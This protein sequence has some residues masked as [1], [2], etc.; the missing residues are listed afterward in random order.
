ML[1]ENK[2]WCLNGGI[3]LTFIVIMEYFYFR[4]FIRT[5]LLFGDSGDGRLITLILEHWYK[6]F[7]GKENF[8]DLIA[9]FPYKNTVAYSDLLLGFGIPYS[10]LRLFDLNMFLA[11]K[12]TFIAVHCLGSLIMGWLLFK[13]LKFNLSVCIVVLLISMYSNTLLMRTLHPQLLSCCWYPV[14]MLCI[15]NFISNINNKR[16]R[17]FYGYA[18]IAASL[19]LL[20]TGFYATY[21]YL[22][23]L[24]FAAIVAGIICLVRQRTILN[25]IWELLIKNKIEFL[26]Y[27]LT[28]LLLA[29]PFL[30]LYLPVAEMSGMRDWNAVIASLPTFPNYFNLSPNNWLY[31]ELFNKEY[32]TGDPLACELRAGYSFGVWLLYLLC[33]FFYKERQSDQKILSEKTFTN[34]VFLALGITLLLFFILLLRINEQSLWYLIYKALPGAA[35]LRAV[36]R[37]LTFLVFPLGL[38]IGFVLNNYLKETNNFL[39]LKK[40]GIL[41]IACWLFVENIN[42]GM[43]TYWTLKDAQAAI[44][45]VS[46][47]PSDCEIM[48]VKIQPVIKRFTDHF[49]YQL[50][51]W[52]ISD[53]FNLK[54]IN[55]YSG[56]FPPNWMGI[57]EINS[58]KYLANVESWIKHYQLKNVYSYNLLSQRWEKHLEK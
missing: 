31:G 49:N 42:S 38:F 30:L 2:K 4:N 9:F 13:K 5:D 19:I 8:A 28:T 32:F 40:F 47:P 34:N 52:Q 25:F 16:A 48:Y 53:K 23:F 26:G 50:T 6:F 43:I 37:F 44:K 21:F 14:L 45:N 56:Q 22:L 15:Y 27:A 51:A 58:E 20:Y 1:K 57:W 41:L 54:T 12:W 35:A 18:L 24:G 55:G 29:I 33:L 17:I 3:L 46:A 39:N 10:I 11:A 36:V 7:C